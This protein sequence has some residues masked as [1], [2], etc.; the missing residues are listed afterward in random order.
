[1][2][3]ILI[4]NLPT[5]VTS[6][7]DFIDSTRGLTRDLN[8]VS[9]AFNFEGNF[10]EDITRKIKAFGI[11][12]IGGSRLLKHEQAI[13]MERLKIPHPKTYFNRILCEPFSRIEEFDSYCDLKEFIVKP[14]GGARGIGVKKITRSEYKSCLENDSNVD[15][16]FCEE[17][18]HLRKETTISYDYINYQIRAMVVQEPIDVKREFRILLFKPKEVMCYERIKKEGQFCGNLSHGSTSLEVDFDDFNQY[19]EPILPSLELLLDE[20][21]YPWLSIDL[22]VDKYEKVGI[23]EFQMEF[24]YEGFDPIEV[25]ESMKKSLNHFIQ[26]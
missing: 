3:K 23:F 26:K 9:L 2:K 22:Y 17:K 1:M 5:L 18:E 16:V 8:G 24:A 14:Y 15:R 12:M 10:N 11:P 6:Q 13:I 20:L 7:F 21:N 25:R 4:T 19:I